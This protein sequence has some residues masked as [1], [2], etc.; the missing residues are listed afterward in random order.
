PEVLATVNFSGDPAEPFRALE[1]FRPGDPLW[2]TEFWDGWFDHWGEP[3]HTTDPAETA[4]NV[5]AI[6]AAGASVTLYMAVGG[7]NIGWRS[8]ANADDASGA[9]QPTITSYDYDSPIG[10]AG[11]LTEKFHRIREVI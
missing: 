11:E 6:L 2:C 8:G 4:R 3:H 10:E 5:D 9:Y 7:T 1:E